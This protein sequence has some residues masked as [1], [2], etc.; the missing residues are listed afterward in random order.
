MDKN[1]L[2]KKCG[3]CKNDAICLCYECLN[4]FC[5]VCYKFIHEKRNFNHKK[6]KIDPYILADINCSIHERGILDLFC[7]EEKGKLKII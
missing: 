3:I 5:E 6:E 1:L 7:V 2:I 4:Y